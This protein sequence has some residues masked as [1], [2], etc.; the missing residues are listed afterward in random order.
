MDAFDRY[1]EFVAPHLP[2]ELIG[3]A[4]LAVIRRAAAHLP[5]PLAFGTYGFEVPLGRPE[6]EADFLVSLSRELGGPALLAASGPV[7]GW[8]PALLTDA[9]WRGVHAFGAAWAAPDGGPLTAVDD[10]WLEF[11]VR[12]R[13]EGLP[14]PSLFFD[15]RRD[16][17]RQGG[18][19]PAA[20]LAARI[21]AAYRFSAGRS[22]RPGVVACL[23]RVLAVEPVRRR[24]FQVGFMLARGADGVRLVSGAPS[25]QELL[26]SLHACGWSGDPAAA[27]DL[28][29]TAFSLADTVSVHLDVGEAVGPVL[30]LEVMFEARRE[31]DREPRWAALLDALVADGLCTPEK[32]AGLLAYAGYE[33]SAASG[34]PFPPSLA[35]AAAERAPGEVSM[36]VR[37]LFHVKLVSGPDRALE[38]KGY[39]S[40]THHWH[41][42]DPFVLALTAPAFTPVATPRAGREAPTPS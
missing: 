34:L 33:T 42:V 18:S 13:L 37:K 28:A 12:G 7:S 36:W 39:L 29:A 32:R 22:L 38:A 10:V 40:V 9:G 31:P 3:A 11:D 23:D 21:A 26:E 4:A 27:R 2:P 17:G 15:P 19:P 30:G 5:G 14:A 35:A 1:L 20:V 24:L 6:P 16:E 25:A 41:A 8:D